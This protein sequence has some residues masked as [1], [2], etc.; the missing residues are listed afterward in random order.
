MASAVATSRQW[1]TVA[2]TPGAPAAVKVFNVVD[3]TKAVDAPKEGAA[4]VV[5]GEVTVTVHELATGRKVVYVHGA[6][7]RLGGG[8]VS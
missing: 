5:D 8:A 4:G 6:L 2:T 3:E 1:R 7:H